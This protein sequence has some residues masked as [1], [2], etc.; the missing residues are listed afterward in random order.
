MIQTAHANGIFAYGATLLPMKGNSY[1]TTQHETEREIVNQWIRTTNLLDGVIDLDK[2]LR[3]PADTLSLLPDYDSGDHLHPS[4]AG[5]HMMAEAVD[6]S[7]FEGKDTLVYVDNSLS[8]YFEPECAFVGANW[9]ILS[10]PKAS[11]SRYVT[12]KPGI[13]SLNSAPADSSG[14]II[15]P[16]SIDSAGNYSVFARLNDPTYDDDSY[17]VKMDDGTFEMDNGLVTSGWE[18]KKYNDYTLTKGNHTLTI[19]YRED[20]AELD[21]ICITNSGIAPNGLGKDAQ[22]LCDTITTSINNFKKL[23]DAYNLGQNYPNPFNPVTTIKYSIPKYSF[24][25]LRVYDV[26]GNQVAALVNGMKQ[27]G[28]YAVSFN[29]KS[30][31]SGVYLYQLKANGFVDTKKLI[32]LK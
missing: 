32:L 14:Y 15:I 3:N 9:E 4:E 1:Y 11:N 23:S 6:L 26:L 24:V 12:V 31:A 19:A 2:A 29:G 18:W 21:K 28:N 30:L 22:N 5:H 20:G 16:F 17:W 10:D 7:L 27:P 8:I 25:T 13:Q